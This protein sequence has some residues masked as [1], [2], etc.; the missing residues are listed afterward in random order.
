MAFDA[1]KLKKF[2]QAEIRRFAKDHQDE[3]FYAFAIDA[4][5]LCLNSER[6]YKKTV[7]Q[8]RERWDYGRRP[9]DRWD[10]LSPWDLQ[11]ADQILTY[12]EEDDGLD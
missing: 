2:C 8:Y 9:I 12:A 5:L 7:K 6:E 4:A 11:D 10:D 1:R 3:V